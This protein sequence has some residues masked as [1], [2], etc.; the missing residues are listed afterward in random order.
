MQYPDKSIF[1]FFPMDNRG[2]KKI[3]FMKV[4]STTFTSTVG[5]ISKKPFG[6]LNIKHTKSFLLCT[7][8][9]FLKGYFFK[10][11]RPQIDRNLNIAAP[12]MLHSLMLVWAIS[13]RLRC[14]FLQLSS[15]VPLAPNIHV[16]QLC[17]RV[18]ISSENDGEVYGFYH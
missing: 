18:K 3:T 8:T 6:Q 13:S 9:S 12:V 5:L 7:Q 4:T 10:W 16:K 14:P 11:H 17:A 15:R 1:P 2:V